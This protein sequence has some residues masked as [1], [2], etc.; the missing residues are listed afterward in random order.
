L[1]ERGRRQKCDQQCE[2]CGA[3]HARRLWRRARECRERV[4]KVL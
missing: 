3:T 2:F 1:G 4:V